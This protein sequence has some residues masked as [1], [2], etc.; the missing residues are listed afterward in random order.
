MKWFIIRIKMEVTRNRWL[1]FFKKCDVESEIRP[2]TEVPRSYHLLKNLVC[3]CE[4]YTLLLSV[5]SSSEGFLTPRHPVLPSDPFL[6]H[7]IYFAASCTCYRNRHLV[8]VWCIN[9]KEDTSCLGHWCCVAQA[10]GYHHHR[11]TYCPCCRPRNCGPLVCLHCYVCVRVWSL[12]ADILM[13][14]SWVGMEAWWFK[15]D[16]VWMWLMN[17]VLRRK[18]LWSSVSWKCSEIGGNDQVKVS[19]LL[20]HTTNMLTDRSPNGSPYTGQI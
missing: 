12:R 13:Q 14:Q 16:I 7:I 20:S 2:I 5:S 15:T 19:H 18:W 8:Y 10:V 11:R 6:R 1:V 9:G 3:L 17:S 4:I